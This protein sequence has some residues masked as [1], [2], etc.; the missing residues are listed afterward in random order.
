MTRDR[1]FRY[2]RYI[3]I[4]LVL[5][6]LSNNKCFAVFGKTSLF[7]WFWG[8]ALL[9]FFLPKRLAATATRTGAT[10]FV[11][12]ACNG[13]RNSE[14]QLQLQQKVPVPVAVAAY[15]KGHVNPG[16]YYLKYNF[17]FT[18][19]I[20]YFVLFDHL[21]TFFLNFAKFAL[22]YTRGKPLVQKSAN[23]MPSGTILNSVQKSP[24]YIFVNK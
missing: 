4:S 22:F 5:A 14:P 8:K 19:S 7:C 20:I 2:R 12:V 13:V 1:I 10:R 3:N 11:T 15:T 23:L 24:I 16:K 9:F 17:F 6:F 21:K 18:F